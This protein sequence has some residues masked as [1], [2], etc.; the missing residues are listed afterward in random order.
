MHSLNE[1]FP[2]HNK[3][4]VLCSCAWSWQT[5]HWLVNCLLP[6]II[7]SVAHDDVIK[8]KHFPRYW[9]FVRG[10]HRSPVNPPHKGQWRG[11]LMYSLICAWINGWVNNREVDV[12]RRHCTHYDVLVMLVQSFS[13]LWKVTH[14]HQTSLYN[15]HVKLPTFVKLAFYPTRNRAYV[16][17]TRCQVI[18]IGTASDTSHQCAISLVEFSLLVS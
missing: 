8:W 16:N 17:E 15:C 9:P 4:P 18:S 2:H 10:I 7:V 5:E 11:A 1:N 6:D 3:I 12:L 13:I 14:P